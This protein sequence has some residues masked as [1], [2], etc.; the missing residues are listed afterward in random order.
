M[1]IITMNRFSLFLFMLIS[2]NGYLNAQDIDKKNNS[3]KLGF[4]SG[5]GTQKSLPFNSKDY[6]Y[7]IQF[8]KIQINYQFFEKGRWIYELNIE[9][10]F[11]AA[12]HQLLNKY[13]LK[14]SDRDDYLKKRE[15]FIQNKHINEYVL[16][17]GFLIR[18][19]TFKKIS[20][21]ALGS[22]GPMISDT[23]TERMPSGFAFSDTIALGLTYKINS[24]FLDF[25]FGL[26]HV[27]NANLK[28]PNNGHNSSNIEIGFM[29]QL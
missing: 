3:L 21:Y 10:S 20:T 25:R 4:N 11:Y 5:F 17:L 6:D 8:Y 28:S 15:E 23:E 1:E 22:I 7:S 14:P 19:K 16:G 29:Y 26:R 18:H 2:L 27:S 12:Q 13:Y 9:P 24:L